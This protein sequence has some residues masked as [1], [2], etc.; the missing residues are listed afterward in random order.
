[1]T[2]TVTQL[3]VEH[4]TDSLGIGVTTPRLSWIVES[5]DTTFEQQSYEVIADD[6]DDPD[7]QQRSTVQS[8][9]SVLVP[10]PFDPLPSRSRRRISVRVAG[11][12]GQFS[13][14]SEPLDVEVALLVPTDWTAVPITATLPGIGRRTSDQVPQ[15]VHHPAAP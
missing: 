11:P 6:P 2:L 4:R 15:A 13:A 10:W 12:D 9:D 5:D 1:M 3:R 8:K 7:A 14:S